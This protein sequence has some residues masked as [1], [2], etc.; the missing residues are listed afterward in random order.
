[1]AA[2]PRSLVPIQNTLPRQSRR[3]IL[4]IGVKMGGYALA[5][6]PIVGTLLG[7]GNEKPR[8]IDPDL[9]STPERAI[10]T[11]QAY[12][13]PS[14]LGAEKQCA[15]CQFFRVSS[16]TQCGNCQILSGPVS[17]TGHCQAWSKATVS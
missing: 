12:A 13:D 3:Q 5:V 2:P 10:R 4:L 6:G 9:L 15:G 8:C 1:M 11:A 14:P 16:Q 17:R 7:C